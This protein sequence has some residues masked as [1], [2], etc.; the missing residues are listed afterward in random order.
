MVSHG[1][2]NIT[3]FRERR[4]RNQRNPHP[5]LIE[6]GAT[7][8]K[9]SRGIRGQRRTQRLRVEQGRI[10]RADE[11][12]RTLRSLPGLFAERRK[13]KVFALPRIDSVRSA[14]AFL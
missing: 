3:W 6:A 8:R 10:G 7:R 14:A 2:R 12:P 5:E 4:A 13:G 1:V 9:R 11:V